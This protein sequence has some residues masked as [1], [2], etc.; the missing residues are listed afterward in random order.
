MS[1]PNRGASLSRA[2][3]TRDIFDDEDAVP[4]EHHKRVSGGELKHPWLA[5]AGRFFGMARKS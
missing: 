2:A 3:G 5:A 1:G 4:A